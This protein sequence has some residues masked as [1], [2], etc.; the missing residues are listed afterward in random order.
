MDNKAL[1]YFNGVRV[2]MKT[3]GNQHLKETQMKWR[4]W[5][6]ISP[7]YFKLINQSFGQRHIRLY[8][9]RHVPASI[10]RWL[11]VFGGQRICKDEK[12]TK[13]YSLF[14][15]FIKGLLGALD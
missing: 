15:D 11:P 12:R 3:Q 1:L 7:A 14:Y 2:R 10:G 9:A 13:I 4:H 6:Y 5:L 8:E